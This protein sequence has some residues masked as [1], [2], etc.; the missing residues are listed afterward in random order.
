M[1]FSRQ[2]YWNG[3][4]F[5]PPE[6]LPNPGI[7]PWSPSLQADS[8]LFEPPGKY[9]MMSTHTICLKKYI[10]TLIVT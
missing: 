10:I 6:D 5:S 4:P 1:E 3:L 2:E 8:L 9:L 7:K